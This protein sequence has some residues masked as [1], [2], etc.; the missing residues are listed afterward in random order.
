MQ[1][2]VSILLPNLN[3]RP[4]LQ[5]RIQTIRNQTLADWELVVVDNHSEDGAWE[6]FQDLSRTDSRVTIRQ[7]PR[8][9]MY[10]NWNNCVRAARGHYVYIATSDD[11]MAA[12][13]LE[14]LM[15]ALEAHPDCGLAHC[16]LKMIDGQ[17][18]EAFDWW[19]NGS[20]FARSSGELLARKHVRRAPFDGLLHLTGESVYVSITQLLIRRELF[21]EIGL[22]EPRWGSVGDFNWCMRAALVTNTVHVPD[23]WG[24]WRNHADQAT[25]AASLGSPEHCQR[26]DEMIEHAIAACGGRLSDRVREA[27][28]SGWNGYA[29]EMRQT[30]WQL[31]QC[32][33]PVR[34]KLIVLQRLL[35]GSRA[36]RDGLKARWQGRP[37]WPEAAPQVVRAWLESVGLNSA[38]IPV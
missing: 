23:T 29:R 13:C 35:S 5:E 14:K 24:G 26:I 36:A 28:R 2:L 9:G 6:F 17:G 19:T 20:I 8:E 15:G 37:R 1:P 16:P 18:R 3:N 4:F 12:N 33:N 7:A 30:T 34:R 27:L 25:A 22:F 32:R 38:T 31:R 21:E 10:A 11:T